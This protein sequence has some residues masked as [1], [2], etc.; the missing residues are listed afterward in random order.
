ML[1][2]VWYALVAVLWWMYKHG[3]P[4]QVAR[5]SLAEQCA[6]LGLLQSSADLAYNLDFL[7]VFQNMWANNADAISMQYAG[8][9][10]FALSCCL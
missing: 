3:S 10:L 2:R 9:V 8:L 7:S 6:A 4:S 1:C 5:H